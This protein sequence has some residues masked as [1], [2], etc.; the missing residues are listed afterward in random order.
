MGAGYGMGGMQSGGAAG[1]GLNFMK[2]LGMLFNQGG[3]GDGKNMAPG[4]NAG[5]QK[6][7]AAGMNPIANAFTSAFIG[8]ANARNPAV[9]KPRLTDAT[10]AD[11][12]SQHAQNFSGTQ[13]VMGI[14]RTQAGREKGAQP[15][16]P[17]GMGGDNQELINMIIRM[18][19]K[20]RVVGGGQFESEF[21][22]GGSFPSGY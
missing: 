14:E 8:I 2:I 4:Q 18:I 13:G 19:M 11:M 5:L 17:D 21:P 7:P 15:V 16:M 3:G 6:G 1:G 10:N 20:N 22:R 9:P 12:A